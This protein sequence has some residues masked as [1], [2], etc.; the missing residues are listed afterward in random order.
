MA[1]VYMSSTYSDLVE[2]R[3]AVSAALRKL[4]HE[5]VA[6]EHY[7]ADERRPLD[8]CLAD[9]D[10]CDLYIG[11]FARRY[12]YIPHGKRRSITELEYRHAREKID[13][14][15]F[16]LADDARWPADE[17]ENEALDRIAAL[18]EELKK[19]SGIAEFRG[20]LDLAAEVT[21]A[22]ALWQTRDRM[23][24]AVQL[25]PPLPVHYIERSQVLDEIAAQLLGDGPGHA[26]VLVVSA[27]H[28]LGGI[29]K[30]AAATA[31]AHNPA[32]RAQF[33]KGAL[34]ATLGQKPDSLS[35]LT[36]WIHALGDPAYRPTTSIA[37]TGYLRALLY[38][39]A[40]LLVVDDAWEAE[41]VAPFL[42]G[43]PQCRLLITTRRAEVADALGARLYSITEM[44]PAEAVDLLRKRVENGRGGRALAEAELEQAA[45]L[46]HDTG[47]LPLALTLMGGLVARGYSWEA[48]R[49]ALQRERSRRRRETSHAQATLEASLQLSLDYLRT[50]DPAAWESVAWL[51][52]LSDKALI[53]ARTASVLWD[54]PPVEA[55]RLLHSLADDA[56]LQRN[57]LGFRIHD[58]MHEV[59]R[60]VL[61]A[62]APEG[63]GI[64]PERAHAEL[65]S[66]YGR[67]VRNRWDQLEDDGYIHMHLVSHF[68]HA[69]QTESI[70]TLLGLT[71]EQGQPAWYAARDRL[72]QAAGYISD[73][74]VAWRLANT[75]ASFSLGH[76]CRYGLIL[77]SLHS[78][79]QVITPKM[80]YML[81]LQKIWPPA[82]ALDYLRRGIEPH[83][84]GEALLHLIPL[85]LE[86][87]AG[88]RN[89]L[90][91]TLL[92]E[93][94]AAIASGAKAELSAKLLVLMA[95]QSSGRQR[96][97]LL[98]RAVAFTDGKPGT[99]RALARDTP[100]V[101][102]AIL[103]RAAE[104]CRRIK[105]P[106]ERVGAL[107]EVVQELAVPDMTRKW[108]SVIEEWVEEL[109]AKAGQPAT[110]TKRSSRTAGKKPQIRRSRDLAY[111]L[112]AISD[113]GVT[114]KE[115]ILRMAKSLSFDDERL[116]VDHLH[117]RGATNKTK[118]EEA[119]EKTWQ[120]FKSLL[121][122]RQYS[123]RDTLVS[124]VPE[125]PSGRDLAV[126]DIMQAY[127]YLSFQEAGELL[128]RLAPYASKRA[129]RREIDKLTRNGRRPIGAECLLATLEPDA[130]RRKRFDAVITSLESLWSSYDIEPAMVALIRV[131]PPEVVRRAIASLQRIDDAAEQI[132]AVFVVAP[133]LADGLSPEMVR[134]LEDRATNKAQLATLTR[135]VAELSSAIQG[136]VLVDFVREAARL[137]SE[138]WIVEA[139][140]LTILRIH[141]LERLSAVLGA[142]K[143]I[144]AIDLKARFVHRL[145]IRM[146]R[147]GYVQAAMN[148]AAAIPLPRDRWIM[149]ADL[150]TDLA[151]TGQTADALNIAAAIE[152]PEER[153]KGMAEIALH[154]ASRGQLQQARTIAN[155]ISSE[156]WRVW[157]QERLDLAGDGSRLPVVPPKKI[158]PFAAP[159]ADEIDFEGIR[160][161]VVE[162]LKQQRESRLLH[163]IEDAASRQHAG[164]TI[165]RAETF[166]RTK[167]R[168][169]NTYLEVIAEQP[170]P[171]FLEIIRDMAPLLTPALSPPEAQI[172]A[173]AVRDVATWWP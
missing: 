162:L 61:T 163:E 133:H 80:L 63:L 111:L 121:A 20:P 110:R 138:W 118:R 37:A 74:K 65:L 165:E 116:V 2:C 86:Q 159:L 89:D 70:H 173:S 46:A 105:S 139:L 16:L 141:D 40:T 51:G 8:R 134:F 160:A 76:Q 7:A 161:V 126:A 79:A 48:A 68:E 88:G 123:D 172:F 31:I 147:L 144:T 101:R 164:N 23:A 58:L 120:K 122:D 53:N 34:W 99:L 72:G 152:H 42:V 14:L 117:S 81:V 103:E 108:V 19:H 59:V 142:V 158:P 130:E 64:P 109:I 119:I 44:T 129:C 132:G 151:M 170:R 82:K 137:S 32:V 131:A 127:R 98:E 22:V 95:T 77:A 135:M 146:A 143:Y 25:A 100:A 155:G 83:K 62:D 84:R 140:T 78:L 113:R 71:N 17:I 1:R 166:W 50:I 92:Q 96:E 3:T 15:I 97:I 33:K 4:G 106:F 47:C 75:G 171:K 128:T 148:C 157:I 94:E 56:I 66:K 149:L 45:A 21:A 41:H 136:G 43:G 29:G 107:L 167:F 35:H 5:D 49:A 87:S 10:S 104:S 38:P 91:A 115:W 9:I 69:G 112:Q 24:H 26:G 52:V 85:L 67:T 55:D 114:R 54:M 168:G 156:L 125:L 13:C 57:D 39:T 124:L 36:A 28:G 6:M 145:A 30:T 73:L 153:G 150:A 11:I 12:G 93:I 60:K 102:D 154:L 18:R 90:V 27:L 169:E